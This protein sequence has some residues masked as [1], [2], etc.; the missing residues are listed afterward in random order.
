MA[1]SILTS[2]PPSMD[3]GEIQI[4]Q[5]ASRVSDKIQGKKKENEGDDPR[6]AAINWTWEGFEIATTDD[7][8]AQY[9]FAQLGA[10]PCLQVGVLSDT[11]GP[12]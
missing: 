6:H 1:I 10:V 4:I 8:A 12:K 3:V 5:R 2:A 9:R 11:S 7:S